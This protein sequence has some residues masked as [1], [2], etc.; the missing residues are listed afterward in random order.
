M[1]GNLA[2]HKLKC[3]CGTCDTCRSR[4][5]YRKRA[6]EKRQLQ[7]MTQQAEVFPKRHDVVIWECSDGTEFSDELQAAYYQLNLYK[8]VAVSANGRKA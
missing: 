6:A 5:N 7:T 1:R 8:H 4:E 3:T 2:D